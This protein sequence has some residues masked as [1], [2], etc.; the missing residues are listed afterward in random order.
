M[1]LIRPKGR[2]GIP[3]AL[4]GMG[5]HIIYSEGTK[6]EPNYVDSIKK[7]IAN[8][9]NV[10]PNEI[11]IVIVKDKS[12]STLGLVKYVEKDIKEKLKSINIDHVW[13]FFDKDDFEADDFS[14]AISKI[15]SK[16]NSKSLS[17]FNLKTDKNNITWHACY[18]NESFELWY[19]LY[20]NYIDTALSRQNYIDMLK[21]NEELKRIDFNY[22]KNENNLHEILTRAGGSI[23]NAIKNAKRIKEKNGYENP[24]TNVCE[25]A[26][27]FKPYLNEL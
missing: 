3:D 26:E 15:E 24:S 27:F 14:N 21:K 17:A 5:K 9:Y 25:F 12:Y 23:T 13:I 7:S 2:R 4:I 8:K 10:L 19:L 18:S 16:N 1:M 20:F 11:D 22:S 6:T